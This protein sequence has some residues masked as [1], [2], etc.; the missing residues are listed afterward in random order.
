MSV[1]NAEVNADGDLIMTL[2][3]GQTINA[4]AARGAPGAAG[5]PG[6]NGEAGEAGAPG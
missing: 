5:Q 4:G 3:N 1:D 2:S 6:E